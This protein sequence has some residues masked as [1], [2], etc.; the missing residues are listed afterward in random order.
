MTEE[1]KQEKQEEQQEQVQKENPKSD[2]A[3]K[4]MDGMMKGLRDFGTVAM[5]KAE[6]Y[7]KIASDKAEELTKM[8]KIKLDIH[9]LNR[10]RSKKLSELGELVF[11]LETEGKLAELGTHENYVALVKSII[12]LESEI[13]E[14]EAL[15]DH[16][17]T[18]EQDDEAQ[19]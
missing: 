2:R 10:S 17:E 9:Q 6:A 8:G 13:K 15:A 16:I 3:S 5:E 1:K 14:K 12:D 7:G 11:N 19:N 4:L 18:L